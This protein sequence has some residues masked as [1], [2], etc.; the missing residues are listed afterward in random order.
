M[1]TKTTKSIRIELDSETHSKL[2]SE[3]CLNKMFLK[4]YIKQK[5]K[6]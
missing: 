1:T 6:Q 3:S 5:L 4:D 2:K